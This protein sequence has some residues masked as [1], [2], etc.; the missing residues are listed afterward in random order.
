M[1]NHAQE[2]INDLQWLLDNSDVLKLEKLPH[3]S[4]QVK[5][6][7]D[8]EIYEESLPKISDSIYYLKAFVEGDS[9]EQS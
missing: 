2:R 4:Y 1:L 8:G 6:Y 7:K 5:A 3:G 9:N